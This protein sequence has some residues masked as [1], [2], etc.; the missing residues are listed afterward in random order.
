MSDLEQLFLHDLAMGE[1][2]SLRKST[3]RLFQSSLFQA[4]DPHIL[5]ICQDMFN[6]GFRMREKPS[7]NKY[8]ANREVTEAAATDVSTEVAETSSSPPP[9]PKPPQPE[10]SQNNTLCLCDNYGC[11]ESRVIKN[12]LVIILLFCSVFFVYFDKHFF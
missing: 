10:A 9:I 3:R 2:F 5:S 6:L 4:C 11:I 8:F 12:T 1:R 7:L